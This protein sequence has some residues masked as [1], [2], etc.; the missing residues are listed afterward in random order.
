[1]IAAVSRSETQVCLSATPAVIKVDAQ[2][3]RRLLDSCVRIALIESDSFQSTSDGHQ[4]SSSNLSLIVAVEHP[5]M[6][7]GIKEV[8]SADRLYNLV[9]IAET[10]A[11]CIEIIQRLRPHV[12][13]VDINISHPGAADILRQAKLNHWQTRI[14]FLTEGQIP[15][16]VP[17][18]A[19]VLVSARFPGELRDRLREIATGLIN[20]SSATANGAAAIHEPISA[21]G[22]KRQLTSRQNQI[23]TLLKL[24][25]SNREIARVLGV[26]EGTIK[27]HLHRIFQRLGVANRTQLAAQS[28]EIEQAIRPGLKRSESRK[29]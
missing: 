27:V 21:C 20:R 2:M 11:E 18:G 10:G 15:P 17:H 22:S 5:L 9:A 19:A 16:D 6:R 1:M 24:G 4:V 3:D 12:A 25:S 23:V 29:I 26:S 7:A 28:F 13:I 8:L 14:C